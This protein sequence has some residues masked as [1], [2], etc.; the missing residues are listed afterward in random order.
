M[1]DSE[2]A[3]GEHIW[4]DEGHYQKFPDD[5]NNYDRVHDTRRSSFPISIPRWAGQLFLIGL[6]GV[7]VAVIVV[8]NGCGGS[9]TDRNTPAAKAAKL[10]ALQ[11]FHGDFEGEL[12]KYQRRS[13]MPVLPAT[14]EKTK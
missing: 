11:E 4:P 8:L 12:R 10:K 1:S 2:Y 3:N 5:Y 9:L 7:A 14:P 13:G 6:L